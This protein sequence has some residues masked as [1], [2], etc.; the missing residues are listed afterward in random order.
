MDD[1]AG[2]LVEEDVLAVAVAEPTTWPT[3]DHTAAVCAKAVRAPCHAA[4][5]SFHR[6][7]NH[8]WNTGGN[9]FKISDIHADG[10]DLSRSAS[11]S[12][13]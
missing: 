9:F 4:G 7:R 1:A 2:F 11:P 13:R 6:F 5:R 12:R 8:R 3:T 10:V